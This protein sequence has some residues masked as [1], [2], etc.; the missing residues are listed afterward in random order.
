[1]IRGGLS[2]TMMAEVV[3]TQMMWR[4]VGYY[5]HR[6]LIRQVARMLAL[7]YCSGKGILSKAVQD[8]LA[9]FLRAADS[10]PDEEAIAADEPRMFVPGSR[11]CAWFIAAAC[12]V[13]AEDRELCMR[14]LH[15]C[16]RERM[17][18]DN[19]RVIQRL[20]DRMDERGHLEDWRD[21]VAEQEVQVTFI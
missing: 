7:Q 18:R 13:Y 20:W 9:E 2:S 14:G 5:T 11:A 12:T 3:S 8:S 17:Y 6:R 1:M 4:E 19:A 15:S 16:G 21:F 10:L